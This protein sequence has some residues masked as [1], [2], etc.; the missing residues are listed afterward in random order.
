MTWTAR[1]VS[2]TAK[3]SED[4]ISSMPAAYQL[5]IRPTVVATGISTKRAKCV[6]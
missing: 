2:R 3:W 5:S 1:M 4:R 6:H